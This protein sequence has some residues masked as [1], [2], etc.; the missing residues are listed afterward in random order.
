MNAVLPLFEESKLSSSN[1]SIIPVQLCFIISD[2]RIDSDNRE[3]LTKIV[4]EMA[5]KH[6][7]SVLII[8][9]KNED[10]K[11]SIFST[12]S[13]E[14]TSTG[15]ITKSYLDDFPFPYYVAI[16]QIDALPEVLSGVLKQWFELI[17]VELDN[18]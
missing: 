12:K 6:I 9:D 7:L 11:D 3:K 5:E 4:R 18:H 2:A 16:Q 15:I 10:E 1:S 17:R 8:I 13:V 14:F